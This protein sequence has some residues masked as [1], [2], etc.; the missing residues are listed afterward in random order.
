MKFADHLIEV[1]NKYRLKKLNSTDELDLTKW[2]N[3]RRSAVGGNYICVHLRRRDFIRGRHKEVPSIKGAAAQI[4][5]ALEKEN[6]KTVFIAT[7][8]TKSGTFF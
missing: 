2:E 6:L 8:A 1:A 5:V 4:K 7:D 3:R